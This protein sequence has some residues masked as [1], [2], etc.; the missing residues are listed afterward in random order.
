MT[1]Q[2]PTL[3]IVRA[4][5]WEIKRRYERTPKVGKRSR[6][7]AAIRIAELQRWL[8]DVVGAGTELEPSN[9]SEGV[10]RIFVHHF[11]V[12]ADGN[13]RAAQWLAAYCPWISLPDREYMITEA[14]HCPLKWTADKLAWKIR[15][16]D[17]KRAELKITTIGAIDCSRDERKARRERE[18]AARQKAL[19]AARRQDRV[20]HIG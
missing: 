1:N 6:P 16:T 17:A 3:E 10:A 15:L 2:R 9:A 20:Q 13:R 11:V 14:N 5:K 8:A 19:R 7:M 12:L 4:R 18:N